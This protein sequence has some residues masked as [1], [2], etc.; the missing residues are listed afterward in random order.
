MD[1]IQPRVV[2]VV[3]VIRPSSF[4]IV[5]FR[6]RESQA[7]GDPVMGGWRI[8]FVPGWLGIR[9]RISPAIAGLPG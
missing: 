6:V 5:R 3:W 1:W 7:I 4:P 8:S 9:D 2:V